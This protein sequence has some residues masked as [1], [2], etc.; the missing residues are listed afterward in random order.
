[1]DKR[2]WA[3]LHE[4]SHGFSVVTSLLYT[5]SMLYVAGVPDDASSW[6][7]TWRD[8]YAAGGGGGGAARPLNATRYTIARMS[9]S[10]TRFHG[11]YE[12]WGEAAGE[13]GREGGGD[14][15]DGEE[16]AVEV[17]A[18]K[19]VTVTLRAWGV[20]GWLLV[21]WWA[22]ELAPARRQSLSCFYGLMQAFGWV[23][24]LSCLLGMLGIGPLSHFDLCLFLCREG[25]L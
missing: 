17:R 8:G 4:T 19:A 5:G 25:A 9:Q 24:C 1:M 14:D 6:A 2:S 18:G 15:D 23:W 10:P 3:C 20:G 7:E 16:K 12:T 21:G 11:K 22:G 13:G